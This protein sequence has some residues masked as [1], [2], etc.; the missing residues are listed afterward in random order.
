MGKP[1]NRR[2]ANGNSPRSKVTPGSVGA[3][4]SSVTVS[5]ASVYAATGSLAITCVAGGLGLAVVIMLLMIFAA[6]R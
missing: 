1:T 6:V 3:T 4:F 2:K 5:V